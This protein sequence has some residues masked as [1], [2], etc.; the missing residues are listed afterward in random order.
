MQASP[1]GFPGH[2]HAFVPLAAELAASS[3]YASHYDA[4]QG[5]VH[6]DVYHSST[7]PFIDVVQITRNDQREQLK[8]S[9]THDMVFRAG[10]NIL[11]SAQLHQTDISSSEL[12]LSV[13]GVFCVFLLEQQ[14]SRTP[15]RDFVSHIIAIVTQNYPLDVGPILQNKLAPALLGPSKELLEKE[16]ARFAEDE[17]EPSQPIERRPVRYFSGLL[18]V[19]RIFEYA[20][21][22]RLYC[23][24]R[25][26]IFPLLATLLSFWREMTT[27]MQVMHV[28]RIPAFTYR[29]TSV[30]TA[31]VQGLSASVLMLLSVV[32]TSHSILFVLLTGHHDVC[33][34]HPRSIFAA[35]LNLHRCGRRQYHPRRPTHF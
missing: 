3:P 11:T 9:S 6:I 2:V 26:N 24:F 13:Y 29:I 20:L 19:H 15:A 8:V 32:E 31:F 25:L 7:Q 23:Y 30:L 17:A 4:A 1:V 14:H 27:V 18:F 28:S 12:D 34:L 16:C 21:L 10:K 22:P 35:H 33:T 5:G